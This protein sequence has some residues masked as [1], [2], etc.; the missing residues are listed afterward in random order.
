MY[1]IKNDTMYAEGPQIVD[2]T[3]VPFKGYIPL[4]NI[5]TIEWAE[6]FKNTQESSIMTLGIVA[7]IAIPL[8]VAILVFIDWKEFN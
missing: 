8:L 3:E 7:I 5:K 6:E 2:G 4:Q 1:D